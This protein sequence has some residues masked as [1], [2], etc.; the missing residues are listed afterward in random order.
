MHHGQNRG[1]VKDLNQAKNLNWMKIDGKS[2][3]L[4]E[5]WVKFQIFLEIGG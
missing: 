5:I 3:T 2:K 1:E 4:A